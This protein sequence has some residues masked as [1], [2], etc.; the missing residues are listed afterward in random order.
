M[1]D[2]RTLGGLS[3]VWDEARGDAPSRRTHLALLAILAEAAPHPVSRDKLMAL[4]WPDLDVAH[5]RNSLNQ[6]LFGLR[7]AFRDTDVVVGR[8]DLRL[9][10]DV[11]T[12]D[13][14]RFSA[15]V[16][17]S[18]HAEAVEIYRGAFLD[19]FFLTDAG[20]FE[21]WV[22]E[23]RRRL[24][25]RVVTSLR[26]L[27]ATA[28]RRGDLH[29]AA[30][31]QWRIT[32]IDPLDASAALALV[33][34]LAAAGERA[35][36]VQYARYHEELLRQEFGSSADPLLTELVTRLLQ[37]G[38]SLPSSAGEPERAVAIP[39][40]SIDATPSAPAPIPIA[41][42]DVDATLSRRWRGPLVL[43]A[44]G[45]VVAVAALGGRLVK[46][47]NSESVADRRSP[48][49]NVIAV[50][51]FTVHGAT[52]A[53]YLGAGLVEL[54]SRGID[55]AGDTRPVDPRLVIRSANGDS[56]V[57]AD[58][59]ESSALAG[60]LA[61]TQFI[62]GDV[63]ATESSLRVSASMYD[64]SNG[65]RLI[66]S[67]SVDGRPEE[68]LKL[69]DRLCAQLLA[70]RSGGRPGETAIASLSTYSLPALKWYLKA[71][72]H[73][74][75]A[76]YPLAVEAFQQAVREDSTFAL[77][78]Y[79]LSNVADWASH[80]ELVLPA[81]RAAAR[82]S[83]RLTEHDRLLVQA[84]LA[85][86]ENRV[87]TAEELYQKVL[88]AYPDDAESW[89]QLGELY[90]H[91][92]SRRGRT[93]V[94]ARASFERVRALQAGDRES[95]MHLLRIAMSQG[96][97][98]VFDSLSALAL[99]EQPEPP[100]SELRALRAFVLKDSL[101]QREVL[102][103]L[104]SAD[105]GVLSV[106]AW[107]LSVFAGDLSAAEEVLRLA[108]NRN[109]STVQA[110]DARLALAYELIGQ[111][112]SR[113]ALAELQELQRFGGSVARNAQRS[114]VV[115]RLFRG[116]M[117]PGTADSI[118]QRLDST[119]IA[120]LALRTTVD[121][122]AAWTA[123]CLA[124]HVAAHTRNEARARRSARQLSGAQS[125]VALQ[126]FARDCSSSIL[127][128][129]DLG[130]GKTRVALDALLSQRRDH[131]PESVI[132]ILDRYM[133]AEALLALGREREAEGWYGAM[134]QRG[135]E[136]LLVLGPSLRRLGEL[137]ERRQDYE[138]ARKH[139]ARYVQLMS[140]ADPEMQSLL[141]EVRR[142]LASL[143]QAST[144]AAADQR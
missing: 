61:A 18:D 38:A 133:I 5:A 16:A 86:R 90:F 138:S 72:A 25:R 40:R 137:A 83:E 11:A 113:E 100:A 92:N 58:I 135:V 101:A 85:W 119:V 14:T 55:G 79:E 10:P 66:A 70:A 32:E 81:A 122:G 21:R 26:E 52:E 64:R 7:R 73:R 136:E 35:R 60:R 54:L 80:S 88:Y 91:D 33:R 74:R 106:I 36:A 44:A 97:L 110:R 140:H 94:E 87:D 124:G 103:A 39:R 104:S 27:A 68:L 2:V 6:T 107:R 37:E 23:T 71:Q 89:Y 109:Q 82:F 69:V 102:R 9:N 114:E 143:P 41:S 120:D 123:V 134:V 67:G 56:T 57:T 75:A 141:D 49:P 20:E 128:R 53:Q 59:G 1:I 3:V 22:D 47:A 42:S 112:R 24:A 98:R 108:T 15:A 115:L 28:E 126:R 19:G 29:R 34:T 93:F 48:D 63:V 142:K 43:A 45:A 84:Y 51:P 130:A 105:G 111:G 77:A 65:V 125:V 121:T 99:L 78:W 144:R 30:D 46:G 13:V 12:S 31:Y 131:V 118:L 50:L 127:A 132:E 76:R 8:S 129:L 116:N 17:A 139:F 96:D 117:S 95:L 62:L 4:L